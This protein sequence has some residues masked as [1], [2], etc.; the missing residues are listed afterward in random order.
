MVSACEGKREASG[1]AEPDADIQIKAV[2]LSGLASFN[3]AF[4]E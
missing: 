4:W 3:I 1:Y 2:G